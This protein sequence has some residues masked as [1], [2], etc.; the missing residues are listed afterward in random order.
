MIF[1][2]SGAINTEDVHICIFWNKSFNRFWNPVGSSGFK[3]IAI[4][5]ESVSFFKSGLGQIKNWEPYLL[6]NNH[7]DIIHQFKD[8][9]NPLTLLP[10]NFTPFIDC[11]PIMF[12]MDPIQPNTT[13]LLL[14]STLLAIYLVRHKPISY[15]SVVNGERSGD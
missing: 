12:L 11:C 10:S 5:I 15:C 3:K 8:V 4:E 1:I 13:S 9:N 6:F 14:V 7:V 2:S